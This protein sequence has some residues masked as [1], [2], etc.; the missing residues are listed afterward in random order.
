MNVASIPPTPC[1]AENNSCVVDR[2]LQRV[3]SDA[4]S[5][6]RRITRKSF[7]APDDSAPYLPRAIE[8]AQLVL[9]AEK[10]RRKHA[11]TCPE[12]AEGPCHS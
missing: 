7:S 12:C 3:A 10:L 8:L 5:I 11:N 2:G 1:S 6:L 4:R 9:D